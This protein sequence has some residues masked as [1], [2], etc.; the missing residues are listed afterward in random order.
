MR[1]FFESLLRSG[2]ATRVFT[3]MQGIITLGRMLG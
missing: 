1:I 3:V 2:K